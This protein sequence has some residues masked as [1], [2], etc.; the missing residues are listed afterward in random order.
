MKNKV[1]CVRFGTFTAKMCA[2]IFSGDQPFCGIY[3]RNCNVNVNFSCTKCESIQINQFSSRIIVRSDGGIKKLLLLRLRLG[4]CK[5][6]LEN[7]S[8]EITPNVDTSKTALR[9]I[10][11][12][13]DVNN[14]RRMGLKIS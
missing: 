3:L 13:Y 11:K 12:D 7:G 4:K 14:P 2:K 9:H 5:G 1:Y 10:T 8:S 6:T